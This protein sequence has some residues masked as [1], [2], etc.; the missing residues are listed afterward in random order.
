MKGHLLIIFLFPLSVLAQDITGIWTGYLKTTDNTLPFELAISGG[1]KEDFTGYSHTV[2]TFDGVDNI[3]VKT[4][5]LKNKKGNVSFEDGEL[6]YS[7]YTS[8]PKRVKLFGKMFLR[9]SDSLLVLTGSFFTRTIDFREESRNS[10][11]GTIYLRKQ[12]GFPKTKLIAKLE[13]ME[14]LHT[15]SFAPEQYKKKEEPAVRTAAVKPPDQNIPEK[16]ENIVNTPS[17]QKA[18]AAVDKRKTEIIRSV[19]FAAD[20][21]VLSIYDNGTVDGDTVS[22]L[23]NGKVIIAKK[24]LNGNAIKETIHIT[25]DLGDSLQLVMY[26]ENLGAIP[27]NTGVLIIQDGT[28]RNEIRFAGDMQKSSAIILKRRR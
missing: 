2:F 8:P 13:E 26:A 1:G 28:T 21:L 11:T 24:G 25:P 6:V 10:F 7:N 23:L 17:L 22:V 9:T 20:S 27:P 3:G 15:V 12:K 14:L 19:Y 16:K 5:T 18:A 4:I